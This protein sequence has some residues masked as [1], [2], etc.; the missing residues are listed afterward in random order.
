M[1]GAPL[2]AP[3]DDTQPGE[4]PAADADAFWR[5]AEA[6]RDHLRDV[7]GR[8]LGGRLPDKA[9]VSDVVQQG[10]LTAYA[11]RG[12]FRGRG[13]RQWR[14]WLAAIVRNQARQLLRYWRRE[15]RD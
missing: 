11:Q 10:L 9:D 7:A 5:L 1:D 13:A 12:Q 8:V 3:R 4:V 2:D 14:E 6:D 15:R